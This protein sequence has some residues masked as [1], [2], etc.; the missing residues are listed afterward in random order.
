MYGS[1]TAIARYIASPLFTICR[2]VSEFD[3]DG[4][5]D[6]ALFRNNNGNGSWSFIRSQS[7]STANISWGV[8]SDKLAP[9]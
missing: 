8:F 7:G 9:F 4:K 5:S 2:P 3:G 6:L 1:K